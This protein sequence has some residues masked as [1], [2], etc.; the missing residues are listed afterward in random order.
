MTY[1]IKSYR[2]KSRL[3]KKI[4]RAT[5]KRGYSTKLKHKGR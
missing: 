4:K 5:R 1:K 3:S 2:K